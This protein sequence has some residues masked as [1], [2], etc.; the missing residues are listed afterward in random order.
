MIVTGG[1]GMDREQ[2]GYSSLFFTDMTS[3]LNGRFGIDEVMVDSLTG[4]SPLR[5]FSGEV[6]V[7]MTRETA[8]MLLGAAIMNIGSYESNPV[9]AHFLDLTARIGQFAALPYDEVAQAARISRNYI[10]IATNE[11]HFRTGETTMMDGRPLRILE[12]TDRLVPVRAYLP[13]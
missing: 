7:P 1:A 2:T 13:L 11:P 12:L 3:R 8:E 9:I 4:N 10:D 6:P 5:A